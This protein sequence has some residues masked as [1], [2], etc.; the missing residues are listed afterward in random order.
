MLRD[1]GSPAYADG[2]VPGD[3]VQAAFRPRG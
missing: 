1:E 3:A 2:G